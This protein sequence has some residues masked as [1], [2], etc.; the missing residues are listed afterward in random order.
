MQQ[1]KQT[2]AFRYLGSWLQ[3]SRD[4]DREVQARLQGTGN[5]WRNISGIIYDRQIPMRLKAQ[6]HKMM[7]R[8]VILQYMVQKLGSEGST[9]EEIGSSGDEMFT[10]HQRSNKTREKEKRRHQAGIEGGGTERRYENIDRGG[11]DT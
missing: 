11:M 7:V 9:C 6:V 8:P 5:T 10:S 2:T 1:L 3:E 4:L